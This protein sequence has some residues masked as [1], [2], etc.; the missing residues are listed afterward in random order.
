VNLSRKA[1]GTGLALIV[2]ALPAAA[3]GSGDAG[4]GSLLSPDPGM[5]FWT[6]LTFALMAFVLRRY[7]WAPMLTALQA[8]ESTIQSSL[9]QARKDREQ[10]ERLLAEQR[11]LLAEAHRQRSEALEQ[12]RR[13]AERV[14]TEILAAANEQRDQLLRQTE[15][16]VQVGL[17]QAR[18][19][20]RAIAADLAIAA[21]EKL[22]SQ[23][24]DGDAHRRLVEE[25][26][27]DLEKPGSGSALN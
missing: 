1:F 27:A 12:G 8:R 4:G 10:A 11:E 18:G 26:L 15:E 20:M 14:K 3:S 6:L 16:Q 2:G 13:D 17:R 5:V 19:E 24:L 21:A 7:A 25:Y 9:D 22:I 23:R